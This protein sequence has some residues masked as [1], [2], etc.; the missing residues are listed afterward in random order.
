MRICALIAGSQFQELG[1]NGGKAETST[2]IPRPRCGGWVVPPDPVQE[3]GKNPPQFL[4][5]YFDDF[6]CLSQGKRRSTM[7]RPL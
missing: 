7:W 5:G 3:K 6:I 4:C 1:L 2:A